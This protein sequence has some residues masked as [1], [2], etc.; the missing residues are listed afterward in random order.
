MVIGMCKEM[1][2]TPDYIL[3]EMTYENLLL[4]SYAIPVYDPDDDWDEG[5]NAN[6]PDNFKKMDEGR[7]KNPFV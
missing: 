4:Y 3:Y 1:A 6:N 7:V 5:V 2:A